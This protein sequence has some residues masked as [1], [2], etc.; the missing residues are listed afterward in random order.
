MASISDRSTDES[1][2]AIEPEAEDAPEVPAEVVPQVPPWKR[3]RNLSLYERNTLFHELLQLRKDGDSPVLKRGAVK[4]VCEK[5]NV[6]RSTVDRFWKRAKETMADVGPAGVDVSSRMGNTGRKRKHLDLD[7]KIKEVPLNKRGTIRSLSREI[8][9]SRGTVHRYFKE[10]KGKVHSS[11]VKPFLTEANMRSCL[12][13]CKAHVNLNEGLFD[14]MHDVVHI[15]EKWFYMN[16]N[17]RRYYLGSNKDKPERKVKSKRFG[18]KV[19]FLAAVARPRWDTNRN[20]WFDGKI[21]M[22]P[23]TEV[24]LAQRCSANRPAGTLITKPINVTTVGYRHFLIDK[25]LPA[26]KAT[27]LANSTMPIKIQQDNACPHIGP[28]DIKFMAAAER[29]E[30]NIK[31]I[32]QPPNSPDLNVLDLGYFT[33]IQG[34]Q[35]EEA[36]SNIDELIDVVQSSFNKLKKTRSTMYS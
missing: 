32:C 11:T 1:T 34:L 33:A 18:I 24:V 25:L 12:A 27:C 10:G 9:V 30:L 2:D 16:Q 28:H 19:M 17:T 3:T 22:W 21:G 13:F 15:D 4:T 35:Y 31:L 29:L 14:N 36:P 20:L 8:G 26:I 5:L 7:D 23:F 6:S